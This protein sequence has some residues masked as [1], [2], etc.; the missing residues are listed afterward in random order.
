MK[1][2]YF[3]GPLFASA[4]LI[5]LVYFA[6]S[7]NKLDI[8]FGLTIIGVGIFGSLFSAK[9]YEHFRQYKEFEDLSPEFKVNELPF[10]A[11]KNHDEILN[12]LW[13]FMFL[14]IA[15]LGFVVVG[16]AIAK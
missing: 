3:L 1:K 9:L 8:L 14:A 2:A 7:F 16:N 12:R 6:N 5:A 13:I 15:F 11:I 10:K 4:L